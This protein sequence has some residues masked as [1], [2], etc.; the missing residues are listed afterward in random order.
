MIEKFSDQDD[1]G[2]DD[3]DLDFLIGLFDQ[4]DSDWDFSIGFSDQDDHD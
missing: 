2:Q 1:S 3:S 4:D